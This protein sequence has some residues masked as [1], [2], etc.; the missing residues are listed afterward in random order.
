MHKNQTV[1]KT[2][3]GRSTDTATFHIMIFALVRL[4]QTIASACTAGI[5]AENNQSWE[6][7]RG[8]LQNKESTILDL[9]HQ[10]LEFFLLNIKIRK[11]LLHVVEIF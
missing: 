7:R 4:Y 10:A 8:G 9:G 1:L 11:D 5:D 3:A 2:H 6:E